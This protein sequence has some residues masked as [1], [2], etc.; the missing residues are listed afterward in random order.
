MEVPHFKMVCR[1]TI[2]LAEY[3][4]PSG[5]RRDCGALR[6]DGDVFI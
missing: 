5:K 6:M 4:D 3:I 2:R 1:R